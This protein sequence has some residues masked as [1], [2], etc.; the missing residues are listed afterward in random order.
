MIVATVAIVLVASVAI[1]LLFSTLTYALRSMSRTR[2]AEALGE[3]D[4]DKYFE[5]TITHQRDLGFIA[6]AVRLAANMV[7]LLSLIE[8]LRTSNYPIG[9]KYLIA[10]IAAVILLMLFSLALPH[11]MAVHRGEAWIARFAGPLHAVRKLLSPATQLLH[12]SDS[13]VRRTSR[14]APDTPD[15]IEERVETQILE[16]VE[17]ATTRGLVEESEK[18][19]IERAMEFSEAVVD[20]AM[21]PRKRIVAVPVT[22]GLDT[23][24][25]TIERSGHSRLPVYEG[26]L[27]KVIGVVYARDLLKQWG[28]PASRFDLRSMLRQ[29][30]YVPNSKLLSDLLKDFRLQKVHIAI[31]QDEFQQTAGLVTIE[32]LLEQ[33]VGPISDEHEPLSPVMFQRL[34]DH[35]AVVDAGLDI[36]E[37]NRLL[38][39]SLPEE[40]DY[41]TL[42]GF[43]TAKLA[44]IPETGEQ[45]ESDGARFTIA[46]SEPRRVLRVRID[47]LE[48]HG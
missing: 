8:L 18:L 33:L 16:A 35:S 2:L 20:E 7:V 29:P 19:L 41:E 31:V 21:T 17:D 13:I 37:L 36:P 40:E 39:L 14:T 12:L 28:R 24:R 6:G 1:S 32:D 30:L 44:R 47:V 10:T 38:G 11:A 22:A 3:R 4:A 5:P 15:Q 42:G 48:T 25:A 43:V 9:V 45:F 34:D 46:E 27:D 26:S 23:I